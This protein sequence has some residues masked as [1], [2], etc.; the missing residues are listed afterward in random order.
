MFAARRYV[1]F[2]DRAAGGNQSAGG[3][4]DYL[5]NTTMQNIKVTAPAKINLN[6]HVIGRRPDGYHE[7]DS[8][9]A[10]LE[11]ADT[12]TIA[13]RREKGIVVRCP[14][15]DLPENE[16]NIVWRAARVILEALH[17]DDG[18]SITIRKRI[19]VAAG[20]GGGSSDAAAVLLG[21]NRLLGDRLSR[22]WLLEAAAGIGADVPFFVSGLAAARATGIGEKLAP[23]HLP[24]QYRVVLVN[25]GFA[26]S[27][28][29]VFEKFA[30]TLPDNPYI[31]GR[32]KNGAASDASQP[33][34]L[35]FHNDLEAVTC[36][37]YPE[38]TE[39]KENILR[40]GAFAALMSG[41][42]PTVFG[43][44]RRQEEAEM[45]HK[46]LKADYPTVILTRLQ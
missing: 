43:L 42:G 13:R 12:L 19:P 8:L 35:H 33:R 34:T 18:V 27:T 32:K 4:F 5:T 36:R 29:W 1:A 38:L 11:L 31:L 2:H 26:V 39:I 37:K 16:D 17:R 25:P 45:C 21:V 24:E 15:S 10:R 46:H 44:F 9:M 41:S 40:C 7:L 28:R 23:V 30:L 14:D 22:Q 20:L 6:L 3:S